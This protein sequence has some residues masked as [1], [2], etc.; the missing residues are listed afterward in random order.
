M[1]GSR[2]FC[3]RGSKFDNV[4]FSWWGDRGSKC[5]YK[6]ATID[7]PA[8]HHL[9]G[10]LLAG[11]WWTNIECWLGS[12]VIFQGILTSI[13][14]KPYIFFIFQ[15]DPDPLSPLWIPHVTIPFFSS[16]FFV[17]SFFVSLEVEA[18]P[19]KLSSCVLALLKEGFTIFS[20]EMR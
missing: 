19:S 7:P 18:S 2:K 13:A 16:F 3:Q 10:V 1:R 17:S 6:W 4:F 5:H 8:K 11:R 20:S 14:K 15:G 9:N 12:F